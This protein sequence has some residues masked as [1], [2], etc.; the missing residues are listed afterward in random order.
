VLL[1]NLVLYLALA[2]GFLPL[3]AENIV[4]STPASRFERIKVGATD[5]VVE[6]ADDRK[7]RRRI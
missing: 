5:K 7:Q 1:L 4:S 3:I 2:L 6:A